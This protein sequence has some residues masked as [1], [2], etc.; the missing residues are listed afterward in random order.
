VDATIVNDITEDCN[1]IIKSS[2][3]NANMFVKKNASIKCQNVIKIN[4]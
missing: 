1:N 2:A 3:E 4:N